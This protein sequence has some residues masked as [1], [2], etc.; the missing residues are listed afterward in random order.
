MLAERLLKIGKEN[1]NSN[2]QEIQ[3]VF[4]SMTCLQNDKAC[5]QND[6]AYGDFKDLFRKTASD[7]ILPDKAFNV[8]K[9]SKYGGYQRDL[10]SIVY[11]FLIKR[12]LHLQI[13]LL[14]VIV[15][16]VKLCQTKNYLKN[17]T[18]QL[19]ESLKKEKYTNFLKRIFAVLILQICS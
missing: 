4:I 19:L 18:N 9:N 8:A 3:N 17:Y 12:S 2:K 6:M 5:F 1:K 7:N 11:R 10:A 14:L 16:Q 13:N 15:L